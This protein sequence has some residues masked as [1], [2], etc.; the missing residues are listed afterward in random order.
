MISK[1]CIILISRDT[2]MFCGCS[3]SFSVK[4]Y[5]HPSLSVAPAPTW[6][7]INAPPKRGHLPDAQQVMPCDAVEVT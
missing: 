4:L 7:S 6:S 3:R 5:H 2:H 1:L